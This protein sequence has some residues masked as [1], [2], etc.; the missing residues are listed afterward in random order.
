MY[1]V[2]EF[3]YI[4]RN[5]LH[6]IFV[7]LDKYLYLCVYNSNYMKSDSIR[8]I[9]QKQGGFITAG[10]VKSVVIMNNSVVP[11]KKECL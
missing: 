3:V 2:T 6:K 9:L 10:E 7:I 8:D 11:Q 1:D 4:L 5:I